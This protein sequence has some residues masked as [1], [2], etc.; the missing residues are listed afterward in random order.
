VK[1]ETLNGFNAIAGVYDGLATLVFGSG[2]RRAQL[3]YLNETTGSTRALFIGGGTGWLLTSFLDMNP[4]CEVWY[5][6]ASDAMLDKAR[7]RMTAYPT[8]RV[9]FIHGTEADVPAQI[10]FDVVVANFFFDMFI[11]RSLEP[12]TSQIS[13]AL[14]ADGKLLVTDFVKNDVWWQRRMLK[15]MYVFFRFYCAIEAASL[16]DWQRQL[17]WRGLKET[18][19]VSFCA[20]FIKSA[21]YQRS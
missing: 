15:I 19:S 14:R 2:I 9:H 1:R 17:L 3:F 6:E 13:R 10:T 7:K 20:S 5:V 16:P 12:L 4:Q 18:K 11:P 8:A 21:V